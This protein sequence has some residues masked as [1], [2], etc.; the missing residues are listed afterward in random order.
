MGLFVSYRLLF[1]ELTFFLVF[2][3]INMRVDKGNRLVLFEVKR[4]KVKEYGPPCGSLWFT[5]VRGADHCLDNQSG[6][7]A[8][9][10]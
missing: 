8:L 1:F 10:P 4:K 3:S 6:H 9:L 5:V 2:F 7:S